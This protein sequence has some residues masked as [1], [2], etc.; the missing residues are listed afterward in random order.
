MRGTAGDWPLRQISRS[1]RTRVSV[2]RDR[3]SLARKEARLDDSTDGH[4]RFVSFLVSL[5]SDLK[6]SPSL[7]QSRSH[8]L[9]VCGLD[10]S[11]DEVRICERPYRKHRFPEILAF[12]IASHA[13]GP[14]QVLSKSEGKTSAAK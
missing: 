5:S 4:R 12:Q 11:I 3:R 9:R 8:G 14:V 13:S 10:R 7:F 2:H 1:S 6:T